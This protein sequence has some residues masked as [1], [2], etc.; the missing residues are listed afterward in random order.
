MNLI[1]LE[2]YYAK[3]AYLLYEQKNVYM[4]KKDIKIQ[5]CK[6]LILKLTISDE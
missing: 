5:M 1:N 6:L 4:E 2:K 3:N